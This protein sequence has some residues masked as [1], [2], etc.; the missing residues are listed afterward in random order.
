[1]GAHMCM[2]CNECK[3]VYYYLVCFLLYS[4]VSLAL[5]AALPFVKRKQIDQF[6]VNVNVAVAQ[7]LFSIHFSLVF[8]VLFVLFEFQHVR[9][10]VQKF[11]L[12]CDSG[13]LRTLA[14]KRK[15]VII[16]NVQMDVEC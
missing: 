7:F 16:K 14:A 13:I 15:Q 2:W 10:F 5:R 12:F 3:G 9:R 6:D 1:M 8:S 4:Q 11:F